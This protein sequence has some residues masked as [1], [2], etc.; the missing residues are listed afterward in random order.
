MLPMTLHIRRYRPEDWSAIAFVHN[1]SRLDELRLS[2]GV[3]AFLSL[4]DIADSENLFDGEVWV[5]CL[6]ETIVGFVAFAADEVNWLYVDP[7]YYRQGIGRALLRHAI[8]RC[9]RTVHTTV[10]SGN[11]RALYLYLGEGFKIIKTMEGRLNGKEQ[12]PATGHILQLDKA[13]S[14]DMNE[15]PPCVPPTLREGFA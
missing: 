12:F 2:V 15:D 13:E 1:R 3:D 8:A 5:G 9:G 7:N 6:G 11:E 10:L 4:E 14:L